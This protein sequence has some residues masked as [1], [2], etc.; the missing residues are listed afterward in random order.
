MNYKKELE[1]RLKLRQMIADHQE[2]LLTVSNRTVILQEK[3]ME[4]HDRAQKIETVQDLIRTSNELWD[5]FAQ[6]AETVEIMASNYMGINNALIEYFE[7]EKTI[8]DIFREEINRLEKMN[9]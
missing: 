1:Y 7:C 4:L 2:V 3:T 6:Y 5:V 9:D 8:L